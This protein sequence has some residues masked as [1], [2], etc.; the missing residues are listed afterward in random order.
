M[1]G[2]VYNKRAIEQWERFL[3]RIRLNPSEYVKYGDS[4]CMKSFNFVSFNNHI[5]TR[6]NLNTW[7]WNH[8]ITRVDFVFFWRFY[9]NLQ[10]RIKLS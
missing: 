4:V 10:P 7:I 9:L 5:Q 6:I 3:D 1:G 8:F 2:Q